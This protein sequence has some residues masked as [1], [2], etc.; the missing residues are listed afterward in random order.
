MTLLIACCPPPLL[1][2]PQPSSS[3][4]LPPFNH[5]TLQS[6]TELQS[7]IAGIPAFPHFYLY[8]RAG[9]VGASVRIT[10]E[11]RLGPCWESNREYYH[12]ST[13]GGCKSSEDP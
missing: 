11:K 6:A 3:S 9:E 1:F 5:I 13:N 12:K 2:L 4:P 7:Y 10:I 8:H